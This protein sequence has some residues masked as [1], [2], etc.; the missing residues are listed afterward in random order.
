MRGRRIWRT[1]ALAFKRLKVEGH[2]APNQ[3]TALF[4]REYHTLSRLNH[5]GVI[6]VYEYGVDEA[7]PFYTMELLAGE[8]SAAP[9]PCPRSVLVPSSERW[10]RP[11]RCCTRGIWS[12]GT[13]RLETS[14]PWESRRKASRFRR[15]LPPWGT[16]GPSSGRR[17]SWRPKRSSGSRSTRKRYFFSLGVVLYQA[18]SGELPYRGRTWGEIHAAWQTRP[19]DVGVLVPGLPDDLAKL[20]MS[21]IASESVGATTPRESGDEQLAR[22]AGLR[23]VEPPS[24]ARSYLIAPNLV[25]RETEMHTRSAKRRPRL[26]R[27]RHFNHGTRAW[28]GSG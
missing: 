27:Q 25:G 23:S 14:P 4:Q 17:R 2:D 20:T 21:L 26:P 5:P 12:T 7:G 1:P 28:G 15:T 10:R 6:D 13:S 8:D 16:Q 19:V 11:C 18:L 24:V 9:S 22:M 3:L